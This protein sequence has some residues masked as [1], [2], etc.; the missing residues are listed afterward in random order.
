M[1]KESK[2]AECV[3]SIEEKDLFKL[4]GE[5]SDPVFVRQVKKEKPFIDKFCKKY[6]VVL[7]N[8]DVTME[9]GYFEPAYAF[10]DNSGYYTIEGI[11]SS[12]RSQ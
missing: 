3:L 10:S 4:T 1:Q 8:V 11:K 5:K 2:L 6:D 12:L 7:L 9:K